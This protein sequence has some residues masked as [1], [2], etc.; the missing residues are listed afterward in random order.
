MKETC[1]HR[2]RWSKYDHEDSVNVP[3]DLSFGSEEVT[4]QIC[5]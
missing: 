1:L 4:T 2:Y 5:N 3:E